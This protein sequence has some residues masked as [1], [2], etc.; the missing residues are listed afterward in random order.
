[1]PAARRSKAPKPVLEKKKSHLKLVPQ[2]PVKKVKQA[3]A[4]HLLKEKRV[5]PQPKA[6]PFSRFINRNGETRHR[7]PVPQF[8]QEPHRKKAV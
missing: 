1:M 5:Q 8:Y 2:K 4:V 3:K 6:H 7:T